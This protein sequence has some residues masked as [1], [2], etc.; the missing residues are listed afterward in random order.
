MFLFFF[1]LGYYYIRN[2]LV[3]IE[4]GEITQILVTVE[5]GEITQ[6]F[7]SRTCYV[8][9]ISPLVFKATLL[10]FLSSKAFFRE[11]VLRILGQRLE[12]G[13]GVRGMIN[14]RAALFHILDERS[15]EDINITFMLC[16]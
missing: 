14:L 9:G 15:M 13:Y 8:T 4:T 2:L 7:A 6:V 16:L 5:I 10:L 3:I 11:L 1:G 12:L